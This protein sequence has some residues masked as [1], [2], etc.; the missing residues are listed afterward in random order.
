[1]QFSLRYHEEMWELTHHEKR[2]NNFSDILRNNTKIPY[3]S[4]WL[5]WFSELRLL[6]IPI[7]RARRECVYAVNESDFPSG[8]HFSPK[9]SFPGFTA[10]VCTHNSSR[11]KSTES[12][13]LSFSGR[14]HY[15]KLGKKS[16]G[17]GGWGPGLP[18]GVGANTKFCQILQ[19]TA[20][21]RKIFGP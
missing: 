6:Q 15:T 2:S 19:K 21:N 18:T 17:E 5:Q 20:W 4:H 1:M 11:Q 3:G 14:S 13:A 8:N 10:R 16:G 12:V 7:A 9:N